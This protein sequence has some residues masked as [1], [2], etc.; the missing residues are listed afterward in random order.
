MLL[1]RSR[2]TEGATI[3]SL[4]V[5]VANSSYHQW[6]NRKGN[7]GMGVHRNPLDVKM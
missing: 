2:A 1:L 5:A 3:R 6:M 7:V 4:A